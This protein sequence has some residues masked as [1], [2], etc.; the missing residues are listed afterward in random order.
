MAKNT[1]DKQFSGKSLADLLALKP[2]IE[3]H[4][5]RFEETENAP[6]AASYRQI[7]QA[8]DRAIEKAGGAQ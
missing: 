2:W 8:L 3:M 5:Q 1:H 7:K 6:A 4:L